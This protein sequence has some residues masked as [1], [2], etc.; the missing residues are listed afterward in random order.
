M[1]VVLKEIL[2]RIQLREFVRFYRIIH[3]EFPEHFEIPAKAYPPRPEHCIQFFPKPAS[4]WYNDKRS[5]MPKNALLSGQHTILNH[6]MT[7]RKFIGLQ[8]VFQPH[9]FYQLLGLP[10]T[11]LFNKTIEA[12]DVLGNE[13]NDTNEKLCYASTYEEMISVVE[14]FAFSLIRKQRKRS[15][16][17]DPVA[18]QI[19][20]SY[21]E[22]PLDWFIDNACLSH[23]QFD[24]KFSERVGVTAKEY[25]RVARFYQAYLTK[26]KYPDKDWLSVAL[27]CGYYDYQ[28]MARDYKEFTGL[29]PVRFFALDS[30]ERT[31]GQEEVY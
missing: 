15:D 3:F 27:E 24:R 16:P 7:C 23:R 21:A 19:L 20:L 25:I 12:S 10:M 5:I 11:E 29:T 30:P 1:L 22:K 4:L 6:R 17:F 31:L 8:M 26:N 18:Q 14:A 28:H 13:V 9:A 2:P